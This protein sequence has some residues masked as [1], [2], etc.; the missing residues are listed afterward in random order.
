MARPGCILL[1]YGK[2]PAEM[3]KWLEAKL[4]PR[5]ES[6]EFS[7]N[8]EMLLYLLLQAACAFAFVMHM[9]LFLLFSFGWVP[10]MAMTSLGSAM[11]NAAVYH[12]LVR[13][14]AYRAAQLL[15]AAE[16]TLYTFIMVLCL[17]DGCYGIVYLVLLLIIQLVLPTH[18]LGTIGHRL[19]LLFI[20][21]GMVVFF[22]VEQYT[23]PLSGIGA[24]LRTVLAVCNLSMGFIG[25]VTE[26]T[27]GNLLKRMISDYN[28]LQMLALES[29]ANTDPLTGLYNRR[30]AEEVFQ[31]YA[32][33]EDDI[34]C[35]L[36]MLDIDD[37]KQVN[38]RY[39]HT[40]GDMVL[41]E[42]ANV[43]QLQL[44]KTDYLFRWGGEEFLLL[45][46]NVNLP[47][48]FLIMEKL[49]LALASKT[50]YVSPHVIHFTVTIG[51]TELDKKN[52]QSCINN[53]DELLYL[54]KRSGKNR[55]TS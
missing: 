31:T 39:G 6:H 25:T 10:L 41:R 12:I 15:L 13:H 5:L 49:R 20:W 22:F 46:H 24:G 27:I 44:R 1:D 11:V 42:V 30:Y 8:D 18:P 34:P 17:G 38:D 48:A 36:A 37:F 53:S 26:L 33:A 21:A 43:L 9:F 45:L 50:V 47:T 2:E 40:A 19:L 29:E 52:I 35:C 55:V 14:R 4:Y 28:A 3:L 23:A 54:G 7:S 32:E 51:L 16:V